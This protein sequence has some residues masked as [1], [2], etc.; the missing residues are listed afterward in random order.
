M[1]V[2]ANAR[3]V[4]PNAIVD[5]AIILDGDTI[6]A[7]E[8]GRTIGDVDCGSD[9][10]LP[11]LIDLHTDAI[12]KH[13]QPRPGVRWDPAAAA[14]AHD[15]QIATSGITTVFDALPF[16]TSYRN[17]ER[18]E[19]LAPLL[20]G[21]ETARK[22]GALRVDHFLHARCEVTDP[23]TITLL[24]PYLGDPRL[25]F[26]SLMDHAP[27]QRQS[28]DIAIYRTRH[29][30]TM[31]LSEAEMD[32]HITTI[33]RRSA[34]LAP[35]IRAR[36][37]A[38]AH[39]YGLPLSSHD[40]QTAAHVE[41]AA[42]EGMVVSEFPTTM[43]AAKA[44]RSLGLANLMGGPNVVRGGSNY[45]NVSAEELAKAG[46]LDVLA[47]DYVP[48]SLLHAVFVLGGENGVADLP[49][50]TGWAT[51]APAKAA[52]LADRGRIEAGMRADLIRVEMASETPVVRAT[53]VA[54][55]RV[56]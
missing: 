39:E 22:A 26:V 45:G 40:D 6:Q 38:L 15:A 25:R 19:S 11:G 33:L 51:A 1:T 9:Y 2:L 44:A 37:V 56:A 36:L 53:Y 31:N 42:A 49:T 32:E 34:E 43:A 4:L 48:A 18:A 14:I 35:G 12:E 41:Q 17:I 8:R 21:L 23:D 54:G 29:M 24:E 20:E 13:Y 5:G 10:L 7:V 30:A 28:P 16:G 46:L 3:I 55:R 27:G 47:S 50:A 52:G